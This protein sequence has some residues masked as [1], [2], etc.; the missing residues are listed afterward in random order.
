MVNSLYFTIRV[1]SLQICSKCLKPQV[2]SCFL[3]RLSGTMLGL[4]LKADFLQ[5][6]CP[7]H[8]RAKLPF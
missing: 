5:I 2:S 8:A 4:D 1:Y 7:T 3:H 6:I